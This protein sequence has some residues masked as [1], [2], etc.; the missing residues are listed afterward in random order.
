MSFR[1]LFV[2]LLG[3]L[4]LALRAIYKPDFD[5]FVPGM[6]S[7]VQF[8]DGNI[9]IAGLFDERLPSSN[10]GI[11]NDSRLYKPGVFRNQA[12]VYAVEQINKNPEILQN[13]TLGYIFLDAC[14]SEFT[15]LARTLYLIPDKRTEVQSCLAMTGWGSSCDGRG[16]ARYDVAGLVGIQTSN[17]AN[18]VSP[19]LSLFKIPHIS[20]IATGDSFSD[21]EKYPYFLRTIPPDR[22]QVETFAA[23]LLHFKW[24]YVSAVY[25]QGA[26]GTEGMKA[27][28]AAL[29]GKGVCFAVQ[30]EVSPSFTAYDE[31]VQNLLDKS[32]K[33]VIL[34]AD[35]SYMKKVFE[36]MEKRNVLQS[37]IFIASETYSSLLSDPEAV[38]II[39]IG[40]LALSPGD[41]GNPPF[42]IYFKSLSTI[43]ANGSYILQPYWEDEFSCSFSNLSNLC[44]P[45]L[46]FDRTDEKASRVIDT[47]SVLAYAIDYVVKQNCSGVEAKDMSK[48]V[49][50][51]DVLAALKAVKYHGSLG[52][53]EFD[54]NGDPV[55][56]YEVKNFQM[57]NGVKKDVRVAMYV[58]KDKVLVHDANNK[59]EWPSNVKL[60]DEIPEA[61]CSH[62]CLKGQQRIQKDVQCCWDC[63]PCRNNERTNVN[64]SECVACPAFYWPNP[65]T[66]MTCDEL[67]ATHLRWSDV[68]VILMLSLDLVASI[69]TVA[70]VVL[71][72]KN[73]QAKLI[74][75]SSIELMYMILIGVIVSLF[76]VISFLAVPGTFSCYF[77]HFGFHTTFAM[78]YAPLLVKTRRIFAIFD[79][80]KKSNKP[81]RLISSS[82]QVVTTS[83]LVVIEVIICAAVAIHD[84]PIPQKTMPVPTV[85]Y[86][87]LGCHTTMLILLTPLIYNLVLVLATTAFAFKARKVPSNFNETRFI[88]FSV[89]TTL[90]LWMAFIPTYFTSSNA[91]LKVI[92]LTIA[93]FIN[94]FVIHVC[95]FIP[96]I[97]AVIYIEEKEMNLLQSRLGTGTGENSVNPMPPSQNQVSKF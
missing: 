8:K 74:K 70:V 20:T 82:S 59:F 14:A 97:Y 72:T 28:S 63:R 84:P 54:A 92:Y 16:K 37:F 35:S 66:L 38:K 95:L 39:P 30:Q 3:Q 27:L 47:V 85:N 69:M 91:G 86:V 13:V 81:P 40:L 51:P 42:D 24:T 73:R 65:T 26:Y 10:F 90:V 11:C 67:P 62:P 9:L 52:N 75:A 2:I 93:M 55:G 41:K 19:V 33:V 12:F 15:A 53:I 36:A 79:A 25:K 68:I 5:G 58:T 76:V 96:K 61:V 6:T 87:E 31:L 22:Y 34:F 1:L 32:A 44:K 56:V 46:H 45:G 88:T 29:A 89:Y 60:V 21:K 71:F 50:G 80:G 23:V 18:L 17:H 43:D 4:P 48:C 83:I 64:Q 57:V 94:A 77:S 78:C 49:K 7:G